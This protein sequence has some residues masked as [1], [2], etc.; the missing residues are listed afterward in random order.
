MYKDVLHGMVSLVLSWMGD[1]NSL[2][3]AL[4]TKRILPSY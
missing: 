1:T 3:V 2:L 4:V